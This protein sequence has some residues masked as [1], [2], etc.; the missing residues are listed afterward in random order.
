MKTPQISR[1][2]LVSFLLSYSSV[3]VAQK[4]NNL[5]I[6]SLLSELPK[7]KDDTNKVNLLLHI[8]GSYHQTN[9]ANKSIRYAEE[10]LEIAEKIVWER[11][12]AKSYIS[13]GDGNLLKDNN[14]TS[15][16]QFQKAL[17]IADIL[18][19]K[20][21][22]FSALK[23]L[24][25][26]YYQ[27]K[28]YPKALDYYLLS[29]KINEASGNQKAIY[30][31]ML[32]IG[33]LYAYKTHD[34][35]KA[36]DYFLRCLKISEELCD[37][38]E[39]ANNVSEIGNVYSGQRDFPKALGYLQRALKINE[40]LGKD[41]SIAA[42]LKNIGKVYFN[43]NDYSTSLSFTTRALK[44]FEQLG[45]KAEIAGANQ[46][47]ADIKNGQNNK[48]EALDY[49]NIALKIY[50]ENGDK[51]QTVQ[52]LL[53][54]GGIYKDQ[55]DYAAAMYYNLQGMK[56]SD[57]MGDKTGMARSMA[58]IGV[59][60]QQMAIDTAHKVHADS[61]ACL[62]KQERLDRSFAYL[63]QAITLFK[64]AGNLDQ[65]QATY[66]Q[67]SQVQT[68]QGDNLGALESYKQHINYLE[69]VYNQEKSNEVSR[70]ELL[71]LFEK[72]QE[73][74]RLEAEKKELA[75]QMEM[76]LNT[77]RLEY[78]HKQAMAKSDKERQKLKYEEEI[79]EKEIKFE[80]AQ[81]QAR[82][83]AD[84]QNKIALVK[85][86]QDKKDAIAAAKIAEKEKEAGM[87]RNYF[88]VGFSMLTV[89]TLVVFNRFIITRK[90][91]KILEIKNKEI[92]A[93]KENADYLRIRAENSEKFKQKFLANM[94][95]EIRTP[96]NAI[97]GM[98][99]L[100]LDKN[101]RPDQLNYLQAISKSSDILL[102]VIN[103]VLDLSKIE[104]GK[105]ELETIDFSLS[106]AIKQVKDTLSYRAEEKG[107]L[108]VTQIEENV[109]DVIIGDPFRLNQILLNLGGNAL[110]FTER[111]GVYIVVSTDN[112]KE[113]EVSLKFTISDTGIGIPSD[114]MNNLFE[115][116]SQVNN[117]DTR[118]YGG[119]GL[120][121][122]ISKQLVELQG[123][124]ISVE[125]IVGSGSTFS[126]T[127][128]YTVGSATRLQQ[129]A[130]EEQ[131]L[132]GVILNGLRILLA[133][134]NEYN[135]MVVSETLQLKAEVQTDMAL[136]GQEAIDLLQANDYDV[137][138]MDVQMPVM[139]G[140]DATRYIREKL[141]A[142]KNQIPI[143][144][145]TASVLRSDL[146]MCSQSGMNAYVPKP[147][148]PWQLIQTIADVTG[149][150]K[151]ATNHKLHNGSEIASAY[152]STNSVTDLT[153][154]K[155]FCEDDEKRMKKYIKLYLNALPAFKD[156][157]SAAVDAND[158]TEIAL[159]V[160]SF[161][162]KWMMMGMKKANEL[163]IKI[164]MQCKENSEQVFANIEL[165]L[166][167]TNNSVL[168]L[169]DKC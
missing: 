134:D 122:S 99:G 58:H 93:E 139:N 55:A 75:M 132:N 70:K 135:R 89:L 82:A 148:K 78:E 120:G 32:T 4:Q 57:E 60:Y 48:T 64:E 23:H 103:D 158:K 144:A 1:V 67:L 76:R 114:K 11:G 168:E 79:K 119:T 29:L 20:S 6:D 159:H 107:L 146:D 86:E 41:R 69:S 85:A 56:L 18:D 155:K 167:E 150:K 83:E 77:L 38:S 140:I 53:K 9:N 33:N 40:D 54:I 24:G 127:I 138:L 49:Y 59:D 66:L 113:D 2:F 125:S 160:H 14:Q 34:Y 101:P 16:E 44:L 156:K 109:P 65:L 74:M 142:P 97:S 19:E 39:V 31:N 68:L 162:P 7:Q 36:L 145:L 84:Q 126:F 96:M 149:R 121:L 143:I 46:M 26:T 3:A 81:K 136:N 73:A 63:N 12:I 90:N 124:T 157:I 154:L 91:K 37:T 22:I 169:N 51:S 108:L 98:T 42:N 106:E 94:S 131:S 92:A 153:Y 147:F 61:L 129:R 72:K 17:K 50:R 133:D 163:G 28:D 100:L 10:G 21:I 87:Q 110:K 52:T 104:A 35:S 62:T 15:L 47:I 8:S 30:N 95:H 116:F 115:S 137:I 105:L 166:Q 71:H 112:K 130:I 102:H 5:I 13:L 165:L 141:S 152:A 117:S 164:D 43:Q 80:F 161:K 27:L 123:G 128:G 111:G 88:I 25:S 45:D 118:M 151:Q